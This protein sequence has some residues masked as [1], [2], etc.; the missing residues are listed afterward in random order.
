MASDRRSGSSPG[1]PDPGQSWAGTDPAPEF[2]AGLTWFNVERPL[3]MAALRGKVVILDFWTLGCIN[4]Q[5]V[6]PDLHQLEA[7]FGDAL[8]VVGVHSGK[9]AAE[10]DDESIREAIG[11]FGLHHPVVNDP[12]FSVWETYGV[13]AWPTLYIIDPAG[14]IVGSHAGEGVYELFA[15][16]VGSLVTEFEA[17]GL[18][19]R[20]PLPLNLEAATTSAVLAYPSDV[21]ADAARDRL[22]IA[23]AGHNR[24]LV[25]DLSGRLLQAVGTGEEGFADGLPG[26]ATFRQPQGIALSSDGATL[27]VADTR[28]HAVRAID[29]ATGEVTTL[30]G[31]GKQLDRMPVGDAAAAKTALASPW[32]V[33][34]AGDSLF[35][36]MAGIHQLWRIDLPAKTISVFA[37][38]SREGIQD[39]P[40]LA[41]AT[42]A[43]PAGLASD[44]DYLY[45]VDPESSSLR[46]VPIAGPEGGVETIVGT[47]LFDYGDE[48]G[49]FP[50]A[51]LQHPQGLAVENGMLFVGDTY[52]HKVRAIDLAQRSVFTAAGAGTR[53]WDDGAANLARFDE[54]AGLTAAN[55]RIYIA[56]QN[57]HLVRVLDTATGAVSTLL[58]SNLGV[59]TASAPGRTLTESFEL[60]SVAPG[61]GLM[62]VIIESPAGYH[63]NSSA[64][65]SLTLRSSN[66][67]VFEPGESELTWASD[68]SSVRFPVP[69]IATP[70]EATLTATASVY[71]C[72]EGEEALCFIQRIEAT[73]PVR[74][75]AGE[76]GEVRLQLVLPETP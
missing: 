24:I 58:L 25:A 63:L 44:G 41:M 33:L 74:V 53:G 12:D 55:G 51:K 21:A 40:R 70:G 72:R 65:S 3:T 11:R 76:S 8:V 23:D 20:D 75:A 10:H 29:T 27:Y 28:N 5:H 56:D 19:S 38:T 62:A 49:P 66:P 4:C 57:N 36:S 7:E 46:R 73:L 9:Y 54:P 60:Q 64:P 14:N 32:D 47:G 26:E 39:G 17:K 59:A 68:E 50:S 45:W 16:I 2:A 1:A 67:A 6:I 48:D 43:Q 31:T 15:P 18:V 37:G 13:H 34:A 71:Y 30:A 52:N 61:A 69:V 42:L 35:V 22:Y